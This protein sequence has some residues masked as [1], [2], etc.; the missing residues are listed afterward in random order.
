MGT[1]ENLSL[2]SVINPRIRAANPAP[3]RRA[4]D[5][6]TRSGLPP[7]PP[8]TSIRVH[9]WFKCLF[10]ALL[11]LP[12]PAAFAADRPP[13]WPFDISPVGLPR[14]ARQFAKFDHPEFAEGLS[15][16]HQQVFDGRHYSSR[17]VIP[18][19]TSS[20]LRRD[21]T[22]WLWHDPHGQDLPLS[23]KLSPN[24]WRLAEASDGG[25]TVASPDGSLVFLYREGR[26]REITAE[27]RHYRLDYEGSQ[28]TTVARVTAGSSKI[29]IAVDRNDDGQMQSIDV[30]GRTY[31]CE[32]SD[33]VFLR[34]L[35]LAGDGGKS[36]EFDYRDG[37]L[38][39]ARFGGNGAYDESFAWGKVLDLSPFPRAVPLPPVV[40]GN[41]RFAFSAQDGPDGFSVRFQEMSDASHSGEWQVAAKT[42]QIRMKTSPSFPLNALVPLVS[43]A[44][45][46]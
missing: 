46:K 44:P 3:I 9:S 28:L 11:L 37:L 36:F 29:L 45:V 30:E 15:L 40:A 31:N 10:V 5:P 41:G 18:E 13:P 2:R 32:Y 43:L 12:V 34:K 33:T 22:T 16:V 39:A 25:L 14:V 21:A 1:N 6:L 23:L 17:M 4:L 24:S 8:L 27:D 19:L 20:L 42:G 26:L 38:V 7:A 35:S